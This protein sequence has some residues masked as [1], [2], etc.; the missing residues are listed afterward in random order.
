[1]VVALRFRRGEFFCELCRCLF[2]VTKKEW[3]RHLWFKH[4]AKLCDV[5]VKH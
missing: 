4:R 2:V 1:M 5:V 3:R